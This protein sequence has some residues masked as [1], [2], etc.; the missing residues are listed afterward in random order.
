MIIRQVD[1]VPNPRDLNPAKHA[2]TALIANNTVTKIDFTYRVIQLTH[3]R[4]ITNSH[5]VF[6]IS[7]KR[8]PLNIYLFDSPRVNQTPKNSLM[9][10]LLN[11]AFY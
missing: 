9:T 10:R 3:I 7:P 11:P 1:F 6:R 2:R 4:K 5:R 8:I